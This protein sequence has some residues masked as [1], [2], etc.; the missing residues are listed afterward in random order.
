MGAQI[1][2][3]IQDGSDTAVVLYSHWGADG[4]EYELAQAL[5]HASPRLSVDDCSYATRMLI[6][7]LIHQSSEDLMTETGFGIYSTKLPYTDNWDDTVSI[8]LSKKTVNHQSFADF[9]KE[10]TGVSV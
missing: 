4:W 7:S 6:C 2:F 10:H 8:D 3:V 9:I 1:N 5:N